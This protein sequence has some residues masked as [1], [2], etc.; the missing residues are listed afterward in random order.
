MIYHALTNWKEFLSEGTERLWTKRLMVDHGMLGFSSLSPKV[1]KLLDTWC[2]KWAKLFWS[3]TP[4]GKQPTGV[5]AM[6]R[7]QAVEGTG[8]KAKKLTS[9]FLTED[10]CAGMDGLEGVNDPSSLSFNQHA[11]LKAPGGP[12]A[13]VTPGSKIF[14]ET[15]AE[16]EALKHYKVCVL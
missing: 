15:T 9:F 12:N 16:E 13:V 10:M 5:K 4:S 14:P 7:S 2:P 1:T 8:V 6:V 11:W 3:P